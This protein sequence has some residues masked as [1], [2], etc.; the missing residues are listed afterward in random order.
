VGGFI[1]Q[2]EQWWGHDVCGGRTFL[3]S[4]HCFDNFA[5][6]VT[7]PSWSEDPR[8]LTELRPVFMFQ[9]IPH[10]NDLFHG[11]D[12][13]FVGVQA[14]VALTDRLSI[15]MQKLGFIFFQPGSDSTVPDESGFAEINIGPKFTFLRNEE[16]KSVGAVGLTFEIPSG[17]HGAFQDTGTLGLRPYLSLAQAFAHTSYGTFDAMGTAGYNFSIDNG[18]SDN[19]FINLHLDYNIAN[20]NKIYPFLELN[21]THYTS[22]GKSRELDFEGA[23]LVN[24]GAKDVSGHNAVTLGP[25]IRYKFSECVQ[26]GTAVEF[27]VTGNSRSL[28]DFRWTLDFIFRY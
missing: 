14:R 24:F 2:C 27:P 8:S 25:G 13:E 26:V 22:S 16:T 19:L 1:G 23:D 17:A 3:Q 10:K 7:A 28:E 21:W 4:D 9:T 18:R 15:T 6:P 11:G 20:L 5:S 12:V